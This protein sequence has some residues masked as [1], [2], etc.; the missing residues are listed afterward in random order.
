MHVYADQPHCIYIVCHDVERDSIHSTYC[1]ETV[2]MKKLQ[3]WGDIHVPGS[4][5][6]DGHNNKNAQSQSLARVLLVRMKYSGTPLNGHPSMADTHDIT[7]NSESPDR[8]A[9]DFNGT[10]VIEFR[11]FNRKKKKKKKKMDNL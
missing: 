5:E 2:W 1:G 7:D 4:S 6:G 8:F 10:M 11:F 3:L 9:I